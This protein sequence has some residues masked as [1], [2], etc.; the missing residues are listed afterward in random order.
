[1]K[2]AMYFDNA[3]VKLLIGSS[4]AKE[5][6]GGYALVERE[7]TIYYAIISR[8]N[9]DESRFVYGK[10]P[11][12]VNCVVEKKL[13]AG[14]Y[15][16]TLS[17]M[18]R[19]TPYRLDISK[20]PGNLYTYFLTRNYNKK[21]D[22]QPDIQ[23]RTDK[24]PIFSFLVITALFNQGYKCVL[25]NNKWERLGSERSI[26]YFIALQDSKELFEKTEVW[27]SD[28]QEEETIDD[29]TFETCFFTGLKKSK[30]TSFKDIFFDEVLTRWNI[31]IDP[32]VEHSKASHL[33]MTKQD[34]LRT[35][36]LERAQGIPLI[37][38]M[39]ADVQK[40]PEL[41]KLLQAITEIQIISLDDDPIVKIS[42]PFEAIKHDTI[43]LIREYLNQN[44]SNLTVADFISILGICGKRAANSPNHRFTI[45]DVV[46]ESGRSIGE[47]Q[48]VIFAAKDR[49]IVNSE[50][51]GII[52][53]AA[54]EKA[55]GDPAKPAFRFSLKQYRLYLTAAY[56]ASELI[57]HRGELNFFIIDR[58]RDL[59]L[60]K[61]DKG[62]F[63][64]NKEVKHANKMYS[65]LMYYAVA[66]WD[67]FDR[68]L[69]YHLVERLLVDATNYGVK[70]K[71]TRDV[72]EKALAVL[73][74]ILVERDD[75][76]P[77]ELRKRVFRAVYGRTLYLTQASLWNSLKNRVFYYNEAKKTF[78]ESCKFDENHR[79]AK[80]QP[81]YN[82]LA[83][84]FVTC[85]D[86]GSNSFFTEKNA[87][88]EGC[89][90]Q[91]K[92]WFLA[93]PGDRINPQ[94]A[95]RLIERC[96]IHVE[97][98]LQNDNSLYYINALSQVFY[99]LANLQYNNSELSNEVRELAMEK[100]DRIVK[101]L[102]CSDY[103]LRKTNR[104]Y[105]IG[106]P[107]EKFHMLVGAIR[108]I[109]AYCD[110]KL[111]KVALNEIS[112]NAENDYKRWIK[113][114]KSFNTRYMLLMLRLLAHTDFIENVMH[115]PDPLWFFGDYLNEKLFIDTGFLEYDNMDGRG[116]QQFLVELGLIKET[117]IV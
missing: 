6:T 79:Y 33:F 80:E 117:N 98:G 46:K 12:E 9:K 82:F 1:M 24:R 64:S 95:F 76:M 77:A 111:T 11:C 105:D 41:V 90:V 97:N 70:P 8:N 69:Y 109:C 96:L 115:Y 40:R 54:D 83:G 94:K 48:E 78:Y 87:L 85:L 93:N 86:Q 102:I 112:P 88:Y 58:A 36:I 106:A 23:Y 91:K 7:N 16:F 116:Y 22:N 65:S 2:K 27:I 26:E 3:T 57:H 4:E 72:Q 71:E 50:G 43:H 19:D 84:T 107:H 18:Y 68:S 34:V 114:Q 61:E 29:V 14:R 59:L 15:N 99:G 31:H 47:V 53:E 103:Y 5:Q 13:T 38:S 37:S 63:D 113:Y 45:P 60:Q 20:H 44:E 28:N 52:Y 89:L 108:F 35:A 92:T 62:E 110:L 81:F 39:L 74:Y 101:A 17:C 55:S 104:P 42:S 25:I 32:T 75:W 56:D 100:S 66:F 30:K 49:I 21:R 51:K 73:S 10:P 67:W